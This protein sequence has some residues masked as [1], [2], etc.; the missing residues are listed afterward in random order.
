MKRMNEY[1]PTVD[2]SR[3]G[4][5]SPVGAQPALKYDA[6]QSEITYWQNLLS[7]AKKVKIA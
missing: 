5:A 2:S 4:R 6:V 3:S 1:V 7:P